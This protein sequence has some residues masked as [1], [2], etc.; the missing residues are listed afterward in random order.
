MRNTLPHLF[1][2]LCIVVSILGFAI[3]A[4]T[5][6]AAPYYLSV[7]GLLVSLIMFGLGLLADLLRQIL[8]K[9]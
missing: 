1:S 9:D 2:L 5:G 8:A 3:G 4:I 7:G 6:L